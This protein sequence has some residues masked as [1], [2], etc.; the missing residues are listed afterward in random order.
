MKNTVFCDITLCLPLAFTLVSCSAYSST[1]KMEATC[2]SET[3]NDFQ[4]ITRRYI[5][6]DSTLH[7]SYDTEIGIGIMD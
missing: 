2:S 7:G 5:P 3:S 1:L 4:R 6:E